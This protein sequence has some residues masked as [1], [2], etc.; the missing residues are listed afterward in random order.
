M[1]WTKEELAE[2]ARADA[3]IEAEFR[4]TNEDIN[5]SRS[6]DRDAV[7]DRMDAK[8][9]NLAERKRAYYEANR[10]KVAEYNRA[11]YEANRDKVA[12]YQRAY[13][14]ANR[15]KNMYAGKAIKAARKARGYTQQDLSSL[16]GVACSTLSRWETGALNADWDKLCAVLPELEEW[17]KIRC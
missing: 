14:E 3:E 8:Q 1:G 10:D 9:R 2:M 6:L 5:L 17:R 11:Y 12:E 13:Y 15:D 7:L 16:L 4:L